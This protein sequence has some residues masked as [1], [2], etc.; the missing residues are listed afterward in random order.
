[1]R[2]RRN[3]DE[4]IEKNKKNCESEM[5]IFGRFEFGN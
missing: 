4:I 5:S 1:M 2:D 3:S